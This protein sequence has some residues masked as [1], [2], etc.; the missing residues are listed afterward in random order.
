MSTVTHFRDEGLGVAL[1]ALDVPAHG[2]DFFPYLEARLGTVKRPRRVQP[3]LLAAAVAVA[4]AIV[5]AVVVATQLAGVHGSDVARAAEIKARV[6]AALADVRSARGEVT[7]TA[8][9]TQSGKRTTTRQSFV[10]NSAGDERLS[11][12]PAGTVSAYDA[13]RGVERAITTSAVAGVGGHFYAVRVGLPPGPPDQGPSESLLDQQLGAVTRALAAAQDPRVRELDYQGR[14]AWQLDAAV[15][16]NTVEADIDHV[17]V[18]VDRATGF[19]LHIVLTLGGHFRS[20]TR[21]D[22]LKLDQPVKGSTFSVDFP[23][24]AELLRTNAGFSNVDLHQAASIAGYQPLVP[25]RLP[26]GFRL[27]TVAAANSTER[28]GPGQSNPPSSGV[29]ALA[30]RRGLE[31]FV[32]TTRLRGDGHWRDPF[33]VQGVPLSGGPVRLARGALAGVTAALV[34][35]PRSLPHLWAVTDHLVVTVAGDL[36]RDQL[37]AVA[38]ALR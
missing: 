14:P 27:A 37:V 28:T 33:A 6:A 2:P 3:R 32:L 11:D 35:D 25:S 22:Q 17:S 30:Y 23:P 24:G 29:V 31:Q 5:L 19:P 4:V 15:A 8:L 1:R 34:V 7:Y 36:S 13:S 16:P 9:D 12:A 18:T 20:E 26:D 10:L 38:E 21:V